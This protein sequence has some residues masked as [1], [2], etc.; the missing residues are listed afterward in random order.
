M[1]NLGE[2]TK[3][4]TKYYC[5]SLGRSVTEHYTNIMGPVYTLLYHLLDYSWGDCQQLPTVSR[6]FYFPTA[7]PDRHSIDMRSTTTHTTL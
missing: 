1:M 3:L 2:K 5:N 7:T 6:Y 4:Q